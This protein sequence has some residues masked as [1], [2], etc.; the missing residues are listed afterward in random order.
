MVFAADIECVGTATQVVSGHDT[1]FVFK[2]EIHLR[3]TLGAINWYDDNGAEVATGVEDFYPLDGCYQAAGHSFCVQLYQGIDDLDFTIETACDATTLHVTGDMHARAHTYS[4]SYND[5][6]WNT[7]E[8]VDSA[9]EQSGKLAATLY[10]PPLYAPTALTLYYDTDVRSKLGLDSA[11]VTVNLTEENV[12]A[13]KHDVESALHELF[14]YTDIPHEVVCIEGLIDISSTA[15]HGSVRGN[16]PAHG[17]VCRAVDSV[18]VKYGVSGYKTCSGWSLM[19]VCHRCP[20]TQPYWTYGIVH[21]QALCQ[22]GGVD[23]T[24]LR[25]LRWDVAAEI[26]TM[27]VSSIGVQFQLQPFA[28]VTWRREN[29]FSEKDIVSVYVFWTICINSCMPVVG[30]SHGHVVM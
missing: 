3:S 26:D 7:E 6:A 16:L 1:T 25:N 30:I 17:E 15:V 29:D 10:L 27:L 2:D 21:T 19:G 12:K 23:S 28:S 18:L 5:I 24:L 4:L 11:F 22:V 9:A 8:W 20:P 14:N 13:V